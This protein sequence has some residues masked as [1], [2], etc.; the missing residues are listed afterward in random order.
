MR[1]TLRQAASAT[2]ATILAACAFVA[3]WSGI[4]Y[5]REST[6]ESVVKTWWLRA[7]ANPNCFFDTASLPSDPVILIAERVTA[8]IE[9][10]GCLLESAESGICQHWAVKARLLSSKRTF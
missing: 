9:A 4:A 10:N 3:H 6:P 7:S 8:K 5:A 1:K 2:I